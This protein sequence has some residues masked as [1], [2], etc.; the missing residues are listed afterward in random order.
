VSTHK[1]TAEAFVDTQPSRWLG[2]ESCRTAATAKKGP[3]TNQIPSR[4]RRQIFDRRVSYLCPWGVSQLMPEGQKCRYITNYC[5]IPPP[6]VLDHL[7]S[8]R[9]CYHF[10]LSRCSIAVSDTPPPDTPSYISASA[11]CRARCPSP[12]SVPNRSHLPCTHLA[13]RLAYQCYQSCILVH[14]ASIPAF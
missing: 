6:N 4:H 8:T 14:P 7:G 3:I 9:F 2:C 11:L 5:P 13:T 1:R 10:Q 12:R